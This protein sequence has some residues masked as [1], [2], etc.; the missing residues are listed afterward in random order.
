MKESSKILQSNVWRLKMRIDEAIGDLSV[1][2]EVKHILGQTRQ[3]DAIKL[4]I[5]ALKREKGQRDHRIPGWNTPLPGETKEG[6]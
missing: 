2:L 4:G 6:E 3:A 5:E 1:Q